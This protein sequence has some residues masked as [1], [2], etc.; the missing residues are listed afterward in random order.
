MGLQTILCGREGGV[1]L[2]TVLSTACF[3]GVA[4]LLPIVHV[5]MQWKLTL[6]LSNAEQCRVFI[7]C[8]KKKIIKA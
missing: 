1:V 8:L 2:A 7:F 3:L 6:M 5:Q 4:V